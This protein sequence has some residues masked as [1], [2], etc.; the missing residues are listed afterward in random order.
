LRQIII[1]HS[2]NRPIEQNNVNIAERKGIGHPDTLTDMLCNSSSDA[3]SKYYLKNFSSVLHHNVDKGLLVA[4]QSK[5]K[6]GGGKIIRPMEIY[7][8]GRATSK[9][10]KKAIPVDNIIKAEATSYLRRFKELDGNYIL[11]I[12]VKEGA[13][14]LKEVFKSKS[15]VAND[16]SFGVAHAPLS[17]TEQLCLD[18]ANFINNDLSRKIKAIGQ[19]IKVMSVRRDN[20]FYLTIAIAFIDRYIHSMLQYAETKGKVKREIEGFISKNHK[21]IPHCKIEINTLDNTQGDESTI[22]LTVTGL[23][24]EHGDDGQVG[25]GNRPS[26]L[27]TPDRPMSLE[28]TAGK[29]IN[30]PGKLYQCLAQ[31]IANKIAK[32]KGVEE[33]YVKLLTQIG[34][35]LDQPLVSVEIIG[36]D[37]HSNKIKSE[38][39]INSIFDSLPRIQKEIINGKYR[40]F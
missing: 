24:A 27:I 40:L 13:A 30:H 2:K 32:L 34:K 19:D 20:K 25:R 17:K 4:G 36:S 39:I 26:G 33:C 6:F 29:N 15:A 28:A 12:K 10:G 11:R 38:K 3:L 7:I 31:I 5:P 9:A 35:P 37:F 16:T 18:V 23:S 21:Y 1:Q 22:Y 14:N 8:V